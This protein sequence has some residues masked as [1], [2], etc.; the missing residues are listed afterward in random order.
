MFPRF[1]F[2]KKVFYFQGT[3]CTCV[4]LPQQQH[5]PRQKGF[6]S[7]LVTLVRKS[8]ELRGFLRNQT[9]T[10]Q[11]KLSSEILLEANNPQSYLQV[12]RHQLS[13][14]MTLVIEHQVYIFSLMNSA[15]KSIS[16]LAKEQF[17]HSPRHLKCNF[18]VSGLN[19]AGVNLIFS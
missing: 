3:C 10:T 8:M 13:R 7:T 15:N 5:C 19:F 1:F 6:C 9:N 12:H 11:P 14:E 2:Q 17:M 16:G 18:L 4:V